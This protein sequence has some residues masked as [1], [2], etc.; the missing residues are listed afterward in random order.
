[1]RFVGN[2]L[3]NTICKRDFDEV[4]ITLLYAVMQ[5]RDM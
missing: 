2:L 1:M 3:F 4:T 5:Q